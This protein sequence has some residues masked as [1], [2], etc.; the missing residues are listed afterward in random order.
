MLHYFFFLF[1]LSCLLYYWSPLAKPKIPPPLSFLFRVSHSPFLYSYCVSPLFSL[2]PLPL[3]DVR[4]LGP[5]LSPLPLLS[6]LPEVP[7]FSISERPVYQNIIAMPIIIYPYFFLQNIFLSNVFLSLR[8]TNILFFIS[9]TRAR[10]IRPFLLQT[11][12]SLLF[13]GQKAPYMFR[14]TLYIF[15]AV[16]RSLTLKLVF[17]TDFNLIYTPSC[18]SH[19]QPFMT[20]SIPYFLFLI[21]YALP[22]TTSETIN[23]KD[24]A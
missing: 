15:T 12:L 24:V 4:H 21:C 8:K 14:S 2:P 23:Y 20:A 6:L 10:S 16:W 19:C 17:S 5:V 9:S 3:C 18:N 11:H 7:A 13:S 1:T 22:P